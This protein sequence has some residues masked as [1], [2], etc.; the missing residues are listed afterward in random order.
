MIN[1]CHSLGLLHSGRSGLIFCSMSYFS[2][3]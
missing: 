3:R 1:L 2:G